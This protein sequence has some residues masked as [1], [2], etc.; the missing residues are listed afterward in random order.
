MLV[1]SYNRVFESVK[2]EITMRKHFKNVF[3]LAIMCFCLLT[4]GITV[5]AQSVSEAD[6]NDTMQTAQLI[7]ANSETAAQAASGN[8]PNQ[9]VVKGYTSTSDDDWYKV[10]LTAGT[11]Y[12]ICNGNTFSFKVYDSNENLIKRETYTKSDFGSTSYAFDAP[13]TGYYYVKVTGITSSSQSYILGVGGVTYSVASCE[14]KLDT[15]TMANKSDEVERFR[16]SEQDGLPK[17]AIVYMISM[18]GVRTT[19]VDNIAVTNMN[20]N[21]TVRL[22]TYTWDKSG[23]VSMNLALNSNWEIE[24]GYYKDTSFTPS[25][26]LYY[27]YP[28]YS[29]YVEDNIVLSK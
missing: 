16:L 12:V 11:Q 25:I 6:D 22:S 21:K 2:E 5:H 20:S 19:S 7:Q 28:V 26:K 8:R 29:T 14:V 4:G 23:L 17:D 10:Y 1:K 3:T 27:V 15:V 24:Y 13:T 18:N 9:Y